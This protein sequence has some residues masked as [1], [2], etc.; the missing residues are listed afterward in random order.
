MHKVKLLFLL[1]IMVI[2]LTAVPGCA[3]SCAAQTEEYRAT[4]DD[5]LEE[6][7]DALAVAGS[8][9]R[10]SLAGPM[11]ELQQIRR[12]AGD[13]EDVPECA[14]AAHDLLLQAMDDAIDAML[15]FAAQE[16]DTRVTDLMEIAANRYESFN[17]EYGRL[18]EEE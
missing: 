5:L 16:E 14:T 2:P 11:A 1:L 3:Q 6:W 18:A 15:A 4:V 8:T 13:I 10:I 17:R 7:E 9:S 12:E